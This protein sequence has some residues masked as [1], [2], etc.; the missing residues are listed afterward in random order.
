MS[1]LVVL[2]SAWIFVI[3]FMPRTQGLYMI[4]AGGTSV[5]A[6]ERTVTEL[7]VPL[8]VRTSCITS[9]SYQILV[10]FPSQFLL[11]VGCVRRTGTPQHLCCFW[12]FL[13]RIE[14]KRIV[15]SRAAFLIQVRRTWLHQLII[16]CQQR[17]ILPLFFCSQQPLTLES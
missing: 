14:H 7:D 8:P 11:R 15:Y 9:C 4:C 2:R 6:T 12:G 13:H 17:L 3:Y 5:G 10:P 16:K 1:K